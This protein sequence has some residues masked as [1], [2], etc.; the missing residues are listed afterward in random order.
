MA[1][2]NI[3]LSIITVV[4]N[5]EPVLGQTIRSVASQHVDNIE[6]II[7]DGGSRDKTVE[8]IRQNEGIVNHWVSEHDKGIY[9]AMNKG[10]GMARGEW[11]I[12]MNAG[13]IFA[14]ENVLRDCLPHLA[15][16]E[17]ELILYGDAEVTAYGKSHI[18]YQPGRH[19]DLT[20]SI[21]HQSM[22]IR[23]QYLRDTPYILR[24][25]IMADYDNLLALSVKSPHLLR[26]INRVICVY[27][28]TG[29]S[30]RPLYHY[31]KEYYRVAHTRMPWWD[32][33]T[34]NIYIFPRLIWS[35]RHLLK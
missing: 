3:L 6:Y 10:V 18:Q 29:V 17:T 7:V 13:D 15:A 12:F 19:L 11:I 33:V 14:D 35:Y 26:H 8:I 9:D 28:K 25:K 2:E 20:K 30:S 31:F 22:F 4:Y 16:A 32:F 5:G 34:F 1:S 21:I 27:D 24:Y 23:S